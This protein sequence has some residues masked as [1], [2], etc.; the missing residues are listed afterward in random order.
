MKPCRRCGGEKTPGAGA[1][2]RYCDACPPE[3]RRAERLAARRK[4]CT[5]CDGPKEPG[6]HSPYCRACAAVKAEEE[7]ERR[8]E[9]RR[10]RRGGGRVAVEPFRE[11]FLRSQ[12]TKT[13]LARILGW[14]NGERGGIPKADTARVSRVVGLNGQRAVNYRTAAVV[15]PALGLDPVEFGM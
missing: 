9:R 15:G 2:R 6:P 4:P 12:M 1:G 14:Y 13:D 7:K 8:R 3:L 10:E 5:V 11:A